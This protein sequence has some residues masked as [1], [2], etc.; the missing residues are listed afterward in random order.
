MYWNHHFTS[1]L[2]IQLRVGGDWLRYQPSRVQGGV[3]RGLRGLYLRKCIAAVTVDLEGSES[4]SRTGQST[5]CFRS[6]RTLVTRCIYASSF[7]RRSSTTLATCSR[8]TDTR[9]IV[10]ALLFEALSIGITYV[11]YA[12]IM[13][14]GGDREINYEFRGAWPRIQLVIITIASAEPCKLFI[15]YP[16]GN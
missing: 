11:L 9:L 13:G 4:R 8:N 2:C 10:V 15:F 3:S 5:P 1:S 7:S 16:A 6:A 14:A 12:Q